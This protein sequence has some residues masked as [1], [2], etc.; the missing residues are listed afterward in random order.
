[1]P[2]NLLQ[3]DIRRAQMEIIRNPNLHEVTETTFSPCLIRKNYGLLWRLP[4]MVLRRFHLAI[5]GICP[6]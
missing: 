3:T 1:M 2:E 6:F 5:F 4:E